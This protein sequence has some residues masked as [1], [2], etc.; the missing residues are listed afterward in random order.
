M[1][2]RPVNSIPKEDVVFPTLLYCDLRCSQVCCLRS[3]MLP[4]LSSALSD[5]SLV[6]PVA[7]KTGRNALLESDTLL[8]LTHLSLHSTSSQILLEASSD[9]NTF[10]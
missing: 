10:C 4:G 1:I 9:L 7:L 3:Q 6:L 5:L 8:K 2:S